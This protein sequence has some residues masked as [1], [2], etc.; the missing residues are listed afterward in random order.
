MGRAF[1]R[2]SD[3]PYLV[4]SMMELVALA[5]GSWDPASAYHTNRVSLKL[6]GLPISADLEFDAVSSQN[7]AVHIGSVDE[8]GMAVVGF[9]E[10]ECTLGIEELH[11]ADERLV[12]AVTRRG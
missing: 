8:D 9:D 1:G 3:V 11:A 7:S 2:V 6:S 12:R 4:V 5:Y 10:A